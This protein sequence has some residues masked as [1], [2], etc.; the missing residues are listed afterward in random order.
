MG[1][2]LSLTDIVPD[3]E[4]QFVFCFKKRLMFNHLK[5]FTSNN[6]I[7]PIIESIENKFFEKF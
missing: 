4:V 1:I 6:Y 7:L 3:I 5:E 2:L